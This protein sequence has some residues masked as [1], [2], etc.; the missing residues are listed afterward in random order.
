M[1]TIA[2]ETLLPNGVWAIDPVH[3]RVGFAVKHMG[4]ATVRGGFESFAGTLRSGDDPA[5]VT[6]T[7]TID[8]A[9]IDTS[10]EKRDA[11]LRSPDF[12]DAEVYPTLTFTS[13]EIT[14]IDD[15]TLRV[16]GDVTMH[17][18]TRPIELEAVVQGTDTDPWGNQ[19]IGLEIAGQLNRGDFGMTF[20]QALGSGNVLVSDRVKLS[21]DVSLVEQPA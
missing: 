17:G 18:V 19:R 1:S 4:I 15:E 3:S 8:V 12:F 21:L 6:M 11:H 20:N 2:P 5:S 9:S 7:L 13:T 14:P 10:D 16:A